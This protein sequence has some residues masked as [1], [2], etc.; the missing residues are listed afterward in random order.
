MNREEINELALLSR[1]ALSDVD[2]ESYQKDFQEILGYINT[3]NSV[4]VGTT[5]QQYVTTNVV[6]SDDLAYIPGKYTEDIM[7]D[8][9][10]T[11]DGYFKVN[12]M[13]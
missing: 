5:S 11:K 13:L 3:I 8:A 9:P 2:A 4:D 6:R 10:E 12:K 7:N 1:L